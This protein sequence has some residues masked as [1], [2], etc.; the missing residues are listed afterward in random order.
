[1]IDYVKCVEIKMAEIN[2][3]IVLF[4]K[5]DCDNDFLLNCSWKYTVWADKQ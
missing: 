5:N 1:M 2:A 3:F 4:M